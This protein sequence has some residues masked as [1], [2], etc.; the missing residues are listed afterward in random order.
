MS[1]E[2]EHTIAALRDRLAAVAD[3]GQRNFNDEHTRC[4]ESLARSATTTKRNGVSSMSNIFV[5][6][7]A[8]EAFA[9]GYA[10]ACRDMLACVEEMLKASDTVSQADKARTRKGAK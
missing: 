2:T 8:S 3:G 10:E 5:N 9:K 4:V 7:V 6:A 1:A